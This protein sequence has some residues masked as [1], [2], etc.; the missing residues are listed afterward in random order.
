MANP[1]SQ[2]TAMK[3]R[4]PGFAPPLAPIHGPAC[5]GIE[6]HDIRVEVRLSSADSDNPDRDETLA[7]PE[8]FAVEEHPISVWR[9]TSVRRGDD[10][11]VAEGE[12][13]LKG[14][15]ASQAIRYKLAPDG[16]TIIANGRFT[17][18]GGSRID[19][20]RFEVG[21]GEFADSKFVRNEVAVEFEVTLTPRQRTPAG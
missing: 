18:T 16:E 4:V 12:L 1:A 19:R 6:D 8:F 13:S 14:I 9:S 20:Q 5:F 21:T 17:M 11:Y 7:G 10:G 2:T 15:T 3:R